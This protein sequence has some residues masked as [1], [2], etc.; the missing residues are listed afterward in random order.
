MTRL[1]DEQLDD[2]DRLER[3]AT[4]GEWAYAYQWDSYYAAYSALGPAHSADA[5]GIGTAAH[6]AA[7]ADARLIATSRNALRALIDEV[8]EH[9][10]RLAA[11]KETP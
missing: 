4:P 2:L 6:L 8:R 3:E 5:P 9:R 11:D 1:T 7:I 10:R